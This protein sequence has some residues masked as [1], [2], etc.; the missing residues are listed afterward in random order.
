MFLR[1][2]ILKQNFSYNALGQRVGVSYTYTPP[3][4]SSGSA[5]AIGTLLGYSRSYDYDQSG[6]LIAENKTN[7]YYGEPGDSEKIV[8]LYDEA[9]MVGFV[10][11]KSGTSNTYYYDRNIRG[12][13]IGIY[14]ENGV[15]IVK[16]SYDAWGNCTIDSST[17]NTTLARANP[18]R[19]RG[20]YYDTDTK[21]YYL[22]SRYY[23]H[24][25]RR[26]ISPDD[27]SYLDPE[28]PNGLNL[29]A[30]CYNDPVNYVDPSG[31][32]PE[33]WQWALF[34]V[35][36]A[37]VVAATIMVAV[38][39][40]GVAAFGMGALIGAG[41]VG[42]A[43]AGIGAAVGYATGGVDGILGG[44]LAGFGIGAIVG[45]AVG[46]TIGYFNSLVQVNISKFTNYVLDPKNS[47]GKHTIFNNLGY[48]QS[49][50]KSLVRI[51]K[52]QGLKNLLRKNYTL[53]IVDQYGQRISMGIEI[54]DTTVKSGW[55]LLKHGIR[56]ITP[57][58]G[59]LD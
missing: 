35:G 17:T 59:Y 39:T 50:V 47:K 20:Y 57:F 7:E 40:G 46:G 41:S 51:Y 29:Y 16:Y 45:F 9:G 38:G 58:S 23:S 44:A 25:W 15:R 54:G 36:V 6:R 55:M 53:G 52:K 14:D 48:D 4:S 33:W 10:Y 13:V 22:N 3:T 2:L 34:G 19:Y 24:E 42:I 30:Y 43:G 28:V 18:I 27:S 1:Q 26:F 21:L 31:H 37:L 32:A 5:V 11:T 8:F 56:L 49:N 12:D